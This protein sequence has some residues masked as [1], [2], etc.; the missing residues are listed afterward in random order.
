VLRASVE[1]NT[2]ASELRVEMASS[3]QCLRTG[4]TSSA[5]VRFMPL[6]LSPC[7]SL[8]SPYHALRGYAEVASAITKSR[9]TARRGSPP[10]FIGEAHLVSWNQRRDKARPK[11]LEG[12]MA[13]PYSL[14]P[15]PKPWPVLHAAFMERAVRN[16][17]ANKNRMRWDRHVAR[18]VQ[19]M[20]RKPTGATDSMSSDTVVY[21][22]VRY[23]DLTLVNKPPST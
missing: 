22:G 11:W 21:G 19:I 18:Q 5:C 2:I 7:P 1:V 9:G 4:I 15:E 8:L 17:P 23:L 20:V 10:P 6:H 13:N 16:R 14:V 12:G 3:L